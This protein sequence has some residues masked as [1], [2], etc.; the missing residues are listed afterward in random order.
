V[1]KR[2]FVML[3]LPYAVPAGEQGVIPYQLCG[4]V[5]KKLIT[6]AI[7][8]ILTLTMFIVCSL[9]TSE[10]EKTR[11]KA[12]NKIDSISTKYSISEIPIRLCS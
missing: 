3:M 2:F 8:F 9:E 6:L 11:S 5:M 1:M 12:I 10:I 7:L 4:V